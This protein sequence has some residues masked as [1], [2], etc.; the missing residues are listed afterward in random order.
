MIADLEC[1]GR[2][3]LPAI[4]SDRLDVIEKWD[5]LIREIRYPIKLLYPLVVLW[6]VLYLVLVGEH[7]GSSGGLTGGIIKTCWVTAALVPWASY[8]RFIG[9]RNFFISVDFLFVSLSSHLGCMVIY[10]EGGIDGLWNL[11][12]SRKRNKFLTGT[13]WIPAGTKNLNIAPLL[14]II[15][16]Y[17]VPSLTISVIGAI[18]SQWELVLIGICIVVQCVVS[19][20]LLPARLEL[21]FT[22]ITGFGVIMVLLIY[23]LS[24]VPSSVSD[25]LVLSLAVILF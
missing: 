7:D 21:F 24:P 4:F 8:F 14:N 17:I 6:S 13:I 2:K 10:L 3:T 11:V 5:L 15:P 19:I 1:L 22:R 25:L 23:I 12:Q 18:F 16:R 9:F 20:N